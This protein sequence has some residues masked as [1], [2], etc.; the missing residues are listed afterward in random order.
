MRWNSF[1]VYQVSTALN[2]EWINRSQP[3]SISHVHITQ[4]AWAETTYHFLRAR[5]LLLGPC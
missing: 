1:Y 4:V 3:L 5:T 2:A